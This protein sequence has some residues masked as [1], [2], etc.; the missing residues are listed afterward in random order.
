MNFLHTVLQSHAFHVK[1]MY[2]PHLEK[3]NN[4]VSKQ[5]RHQPSCTSTEYGQRLE[6]LDIEKEE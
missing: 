2:E 6:I 4:E 3:T 1:S 5:V